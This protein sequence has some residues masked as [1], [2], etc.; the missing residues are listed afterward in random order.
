MPAYIVVDVTVHDPI[1]YEPYKKMAFDAVT[2]YGGRYI[3]RGGEIDLREG[4]Y[5]PNRFVIVEFPT[6]AQ[7]RAFYE[8][9]EY[10]PALAIRKS[11]ATSNLVIV[12]GWPPS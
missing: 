12:D 6:L 4:E 10:A 2:R 9:P 11:V 3:V 1:A 7:A 5:K 8:S